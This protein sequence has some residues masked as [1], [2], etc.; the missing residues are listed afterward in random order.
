M[1]HERPAN[2]KS[3][4][5]PLPWPSQ[6]R[7][8]WEPH[9]GRWLEGFSIGSAVCGFA[10]Q[11]LLVPAVL[12]FVVGL[13]VWIASNH[14]LVKMRANL[15]DPHGQMATEKCSQ[16][17]H[18]RHRPECLHLGDDSYLCGNP[19]SIVGCLHL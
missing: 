7:R 9:R 10:S 16:L 11:V 2:S 12:G 19:F 8:D 15:M 3:V 4:E 13:V 6:V 17:E 14:D 18:D 1:R 5:Q